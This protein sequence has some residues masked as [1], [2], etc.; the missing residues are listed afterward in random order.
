MALG[1]LVD[2]Q[3]RLAERIEDLVVRAELDPLQAEVGARPLELVLGAVDLGMDREEADPASG[4]RCDELGDRVVEAAVDARAV[5]GDREGDGH[6]DVRERL[7]VVGPGRRCGHR[8]V[9]A[10]GRV[11]DELVLRDMVAVGRNVRVDVDHAASSRLGLTS[12]IASRWV[13]VE[14]ELVE[15][16]DAQPGVALHRLGAQQPASVPKSS[17]SSGQRA[18]IARIA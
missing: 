15:L 8:A 6:V 9:G 17:R 13:C 14:A 11:D 4:R 3:R 12:R 5:A 7:F 18:T 2:A 1:E 16:A 10:P